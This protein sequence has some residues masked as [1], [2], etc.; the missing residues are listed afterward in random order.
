MVAP[1]RSAEASN[2]SLV[3]FLL[4]LF[5]TGEYEQRLYAYFK[6]QVKFVVLAWQHEQELS[7]DV[8]SC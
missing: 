3:C 6:R 4:A 2:A 7:N 8:S 1:E 5:N